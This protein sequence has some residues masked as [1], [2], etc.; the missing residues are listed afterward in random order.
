[1]TVPAITQPTLIYNGNTIRDD[2]EFLNL[3]DMWRAASE[4]EGKRPANWA[5]KEGAQFIEFISENLN[6]PVGHIWIA[7]RGRHSE[8][9]VFFPGAFRGITDEHHP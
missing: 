7:E 8:T 4:P 1:M 2:G 5:R 6:M 3:T 9:G